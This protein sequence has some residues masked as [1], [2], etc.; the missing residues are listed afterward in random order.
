MFIVFSTPN[1]LHLR[2]NTRDSSYHCLFFFSFSIAVESITTKRT[3]YPAIL[4]SRFAFQ[5]TLG[6]FLFCLSFFV[7]VFSVVF[8][9][10]VFTSLPLSKIHQISIREK[11][12]QHSQHVSGFLYDSRNS[13]LLHIA[14]NTLVTHVVFHLFHFHRD[15][16]DAIRATYYLHGF[17]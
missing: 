3:C 7:L 11:L 12:M 15:S 10:Q 13:I 9:R 8:F 14:Q 5:Y 16:I 17:M 2:Q 4:F 1:Q 6:Y